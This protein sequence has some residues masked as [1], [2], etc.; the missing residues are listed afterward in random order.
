MCLFRLA[1]LQQDM[2]H[3][4]CQLVVLSPLPLLCLLSIEYYWA[5]LFSAYEKYESSS[6]WN[7]CGQNKRL[8]RWEIA[9]HL[10]KVFDFHYLLHHVAVLLVVVVSW[11]SVMP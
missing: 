11:H 2:S 8:E 10:F 7:Q 4:Q 9:P 3:F 6:D 1:Q 5:C